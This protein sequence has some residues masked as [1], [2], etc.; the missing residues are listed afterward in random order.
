MNIKIVDSWLR[1]YLDTRESSSQ[2]AKELSLSSVSVERV[3]K[4][5]NDSIYDIEVTTNRPDLMSIMG[6]ARE[7]S[8]VLKNA[9][10]NDLKTKTIPNSSTKFPIEI[11]NDPKLVNRI[12]AVVLE[13]KIGDSPKE[14]KDRLENSGIRSLNNLIDVTNY[15]MREIGHPAHVFDFDLLKTQKMIIRESKRGESVTTLDGK[16]HE[17][18]GEDIVADD[19]TGKIIDL[20]GVMGTANSVIQQDTKR[21]LF[22]IDNNN[23]VNIRNTS[24]SL[25]IRSEAA[26]LNEKGVDPEHCLKTLLRGIE[27]YE[28]IANAKV[29]SEIF[30][31]YPNKPRT[32]TIIVDSEKINR[33]IGVDINPQNSV[34]ILNKLGF[35]AKRLG[36]KIEVEVPTIRADVR[37][38]EDVIEEIAR[39]YGYHNLPS[40]V[41]TFLPNKTLGFANNFYF[42][43]RIKNAFKYFGFSEVYTYS[44]VSEDLFDG[45]IENAVKLKNPLSKDL[46]YLR[47]SLIPSLL[48]VTS[49]NKAIE[50]FK[51]FEIANI[52]LKKQNDL[53][54]ET[55]MLSGVLKKKHA[56]FYEVKGVIEQAL[57]DLG[58]KNL[59][60]KKSQ[61][62]SIGASIYIDKDYLGEIEVL[63]TNI[64]DFELNFEIILK[65]ATNSKVFK[66]FAKFPPIIEDISVICDA[67]TQE[68]VNT[69]KN[70]DEKIVDVTLKDTY[71]E[72]RTFH[73]VYQDFEKN[74][75][76]EEVAKI[77]E[78][79]VSVLKKTFN[80]TIKE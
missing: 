53:P 69:I 58:I 11:K 37:L 57:N 3:E 26:I 75:T 14:I 46:T 71:K 6:I 39:V 10:F 62:S 32:T 40:I 20:L 44:L 35:K 55:P 56:S 48:D 12:C 73:I 25:G 66:P 15:V 80:A 1:E 76:K 19:G 5:D 41:P 34:E 27:L 60:F 17:L 59:I 31:H 63:D 7:A 45:P 24:M 43:K 70:Q 8:A 38:D 42:E 67:Q 61:K 50:E 78:K 36:E 74:L 68:V 9:K 30:D 52:Y 47:N 16:R 23:P 54:K 64:I 33:V 72:S 79:I 49:D 51:V 13:V 21:I 4:V 2:I 29:I 65:H 22:F 77:R 18:L 28:K